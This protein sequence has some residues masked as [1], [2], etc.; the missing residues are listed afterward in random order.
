LYQFPSP[1]QVS[2]EPSGNRVKK[3]SRQS[4]AKPD[5]AREKIRGLVLNTLLFKGGAPA[6]ESAGPRLR[7]P[8]MPACL[9]ALASPPLQ[10]ISHF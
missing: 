1:L 8:S 9:R 6:K 2:A 5:Q 7:P 3:P 10:L 4:I